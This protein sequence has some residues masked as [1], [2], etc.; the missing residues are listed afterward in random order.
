ME[1]SWLAKGLSESYSLLKWGEKKKLLRESF[2]NSFGLNTS[3]LILNKYILKIIKDPQTK[4][5]SELY[6]SLFTIFKIE[7]LKD[8]Y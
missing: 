3:L 5:L 7:T 4:C 2:S 8:I 6:L 1:K